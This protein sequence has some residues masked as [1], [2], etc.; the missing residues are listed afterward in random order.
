MEAETEDATRACVFIFT[1]GAGS[2]KIVNGSELDVP[3]PGKGVNTVIGEVP[4]VT[5]SAAEMDASIPVV[6][7]N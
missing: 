6:P 5:I 7:M 2:A 1:A 3:P 4:A